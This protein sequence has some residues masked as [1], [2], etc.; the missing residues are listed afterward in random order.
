MRKIIAIPN[1]NKDGFFI[2]SEI[3]RNTFLDW[4]KKYKTFHIFPA[5][6]E[7]I[8]SRGYLEGAV[9]P[10]YCEWQ[11]GINPKKIGLSEQRRFL[12][13]RD[14]NSEIINDRN[15]NPIKAPISSKGKASYLVNVYT[16]YC[17]ENG[18][19][20]PNPEL[21]KLWRDRY[22]I[23]YRFPTFFDFL[24]FLDLQCDSMPSDQT[25]NKLKCDEVKIKYPKEDIDPDK[26]PF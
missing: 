4:L 22:A 20:L 23:D 24:D 25:L 9:I 12:F 7:S 16:Q 5:D 19:P 11:Y 14:F 6:Q 26:C 3:N 13:K 18:A 17:Y 10:A 15:G 2:P 8:K 21:Y 1:K